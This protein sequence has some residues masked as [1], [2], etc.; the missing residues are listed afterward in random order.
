VDITVSSRDAEVT[1][2]VRAACQDKLGKLSRFLDQTARADVHFFEEKNRRIADREV[3]EV[4]LEAKRHH[5]VA[6]AAGPDHFVA[7]DRVVQKLQHQLQKVKTQRQ[8]RGQ[9]RRGESVDSRG[10]HNG[11]DTGNGGG[12]DDD[13]GPGA[14]RTGSSRRIG[15]KRRPPPEAAPLM[16]VVDQPASSL[17]GLL[18]DD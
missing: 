15:T 4:T 7:I 6:K 10:S 1:A 18:G 2:A 17:I 5:L 12:D 11:L 3:C 8:R 13:G 9:P 16:D 14:V